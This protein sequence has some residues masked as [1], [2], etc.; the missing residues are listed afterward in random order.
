MQSYRADQETRKAIETILEQMNT[1]YQNKDL[2]AFISLFA[3]D[4]NMMT[5]GLEEDQM[6]IG[7]NQLEQRMKK[8]FED[9]LQNLIS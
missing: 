9:T 7:L 6:S 8:T 5:I 4:P 2:A 3:N 1:A